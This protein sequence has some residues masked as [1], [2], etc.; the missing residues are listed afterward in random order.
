LYQQ[1]RIEITKKNIPNMKKKTNSGNPKLK[2]SKEKIAVLS[3]KQIAGIKA[4]NQEEAARSTL[5]DFTC[6]WCTKVLPPYEP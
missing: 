3:G 4:G 2:L 6:T 5:N 1:I